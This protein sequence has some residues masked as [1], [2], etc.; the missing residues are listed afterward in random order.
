MN[1]HA[2][3]TSSVNRFQ[4][5]T[6]MLKSVGKASSS[7]KVIPFKNGNTGFTGI[8]QPQPGQHLKPL[9]TKFST[10]NLKSSVLHQPING[11]QLNHTV[12]KLATSKFKTNVLGKFDNVGTH[13]NNHS[14]VV[15]KLQ[16]QGNLGDIF[17]QQGSSKGLPGPIAKSNK[18]GPSQ[19][20]HYGCP[21]PSYFFF[22]SY[23][24]YY[25]PAAGSY[26]CGTTVIYH[27]TPAVTQVVEV[28][29]TQDAPIQQVSAVEP[30]TPAS[31]D[32]IVD[33]IQLVTPETASQGAVYRV[34][35][36]NQGTATASAF[37][38]GLVVG[39]EGRPIEDSPRAVAEVPSLA[40][41]QAGEA[42][43][44]LPK[45][46]LKQVETAGAQ[47]RDFSFLAAAADVDERVT[48]TDKANNII[49]VPRSDLNTIA[50][51]N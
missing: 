43:I 25:W 2:V 18:C 30:A 6:T 47:P 44:Q 23:N 24:P 22:P 41:S 3:H 32:L 39:F 51:M 42:Q 49:S 11:Q 40:P 28:P 8:G 14:S 35:F 38:I 48:E 19:S 5:S 26:G 50:A 31:A 29:A 12:N 21:W 37:R 16:H 46:A 33:A 7:N 15:S 1:S 9:G 36:H 4:G 17:K 10:T 27:T 34:K 13:T 45:G 20:C